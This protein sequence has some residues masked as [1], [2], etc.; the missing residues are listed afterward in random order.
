M[1]TRDGAWPAVGREEVPWKSRYDDD[2]WIPR[3]RRRKILETY[4][5]AV[6]GPIAEATPR[7]D[8][9]LWPLVSE[10]GREL[11]RFDAE[12][13]ARGYDLPALLLRSESSA[14]SQIEHL[15]SSARNIAWAEVSADL[16]ENARLIARNLDAMRRALGE[17]G[18]I[19]AD[20]VV[21]VHGALMGEV[22]GLR[23]EQVWVGGTPYSPHGALFVPPQPGRV[24]ALVDDLVA[25]AHRDDIDPVVKAACFHGQFETV[26]PF[27]DGNGRCGRALIHRMLKDDGVCRVQ[28]MPLSA[29]LL[30]DVGRYMD[31]I[32]A[33]QEGDVSPLVGRLAES[34]LY[35][36]AVAKM[37][38]SAID[39]VMGRWREAI[40][41]RP[42]GAASRLLAHLVAQPVTS[43]AIASKAIGVSERQASNILAKACETEVVRPCGNRRR[44]RFFQATELLEIVDAVAAEDGLRR[45]MLR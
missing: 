3:S 41:A 23:G 16:P 12:Q 39:S 24:A 40:G 38:A 34:V 10:A 30:Q 7:P 28:V 8:P 5:A 31:A 33:Y 45:K 35:G 13:A 22:W 36:V 32:D 2:S 43:V 9:G 11:A 44:G 18:P 21:S 14:S 17:A 19:T 29:G 25:F 37:A 1:G 42:T 4:G 6:P 27:A 26:H 20:T 15:T